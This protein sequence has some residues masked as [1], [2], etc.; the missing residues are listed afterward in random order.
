MFAATTHQVVKSLGKDSLTPVRSVDGAYNI[1]PFSVVLKER[2]RRLIFWKRTKCLT[3]E[4]NLNMILST[5]WTD[6]ERTS[7]VKKWTLAKFDFETDFSLNGKFGIDLHDELL[8]VDFDASR[9][10][11][12]KSTLGEL[13]KE[14]VDLQGFIDATRNRTL[15]L[16][17]QLVAPL[18]DD[19]SKT[20]CLVTGV[21]RL[22]KEASI[23]GKKSCKGSEELNLTKVANENAEVQE[24]KDKSLM[25]PANTALAYTVYELQVSKQNGRFSLMLVPGQRGGFVTSLSVD[26]DDIDGPSDAMGATTLFQGIQTM[27]EE[28]RE[29]LQ[30]CTIRIVQ[31]PKC[32]DPLNDLLHKAADFLEMNIEKTSTMQ[33]L[34]DK[35]PSLDDILLDFLTL[36]GFQKQDD[37]TIVYPVCST[38]VF[39]S[40]ELLVSLLNELGDEEL[41]VMATCLQDLPVSQAIITALRPVWES[42]Q[43]EVTLE[44]DQSWMT[45]DTGRRLTEVFGVDYDGHC[46]RVPADN[47]LDTQAL[48]LVLDAFLANV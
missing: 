44:G 40:C 1:A 42:D 39:E 9:T 29:M 6:D 11:T 34:R 21:V 16:K 35:I 4:F 45:T 32:L 27:S 19:S 24:S 15:D 25:I 7:L 8:D 38:E 10:V 18:L 23:V 31:V 17:H 30:K 33:S 47:L 5:P 20:L 12:V 22:T 43:C 48:Y 13:S 26:L 28:G 3:T 37:E 2:R 36:A 14:E 41:E 46:L